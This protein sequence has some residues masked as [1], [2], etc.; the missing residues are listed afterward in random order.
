VFGP[1][2]GSTVLRDPESATVGMRRF[3]P[4]HTQALA[5]SNPGARRLDIL[6]KSAGRAT[7]V[8]RVGRRAVWNPRGAGTR[9]LMTRTVTTVRPP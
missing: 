3:R 7:A 9:R 6:A 5:M 8:E 1:D 2:A 4:Q